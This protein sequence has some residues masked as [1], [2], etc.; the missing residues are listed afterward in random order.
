MNLLLECPTCR[1][2]SEHEILKEARDLLVRCVECGTVHHVPLSAK[3]QE[4]TIRTIVSHEDE[5]RVCAAEL[6]SDEKCTLGDLIVAEC[7]D[8][9]FGVEVTGIECG[10]RR[11]RRATADSITTLWTRMID[12]VV[13]KVSVHEQRTTKPLYIRCAGE[14]DFEIGKVYEVGNMRFRVTNI[15]L[16]DGALMRKEGWKA[17]A[18][19]IKRL[20][21]RRI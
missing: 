15:K 5:S 1:G 4:L 20:Y 11:V 17:Y 7:G 2:R 18:R 16:R 3:P 8:E 12:E 21:A 13:L 10:E 9:A 6:F 19:K 14:E